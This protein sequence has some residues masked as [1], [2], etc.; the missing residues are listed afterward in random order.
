M[1]VLVCY[2][3][4]VH[5]VCVLGVVFVHMRAHFQVPCGGGGESE[6]GRVSEKVCITDGV[7]KFDAL[8]ELFARYTIKDS[9]RSGCWGR[10]LACGSGASPWCLWVLNALSFVRRVGLPIGQRKGSREQGVMCHVAAPCPE[11]PPRP[12]AVRKFRRQMP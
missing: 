7:D 2:F 3:V 12:K 4:C 11:P 10:Q 5:F 9:L 1:Y 8:R 6:N